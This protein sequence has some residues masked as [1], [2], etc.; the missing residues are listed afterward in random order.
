MSTAAEPVVGGEV[1]G[2][3]R[4]RRS[5]GNKL[6]RRRGPRAN[7]ESKPEG[8]T[9]VRAERPESIPVPA[10]M[11]GQRKIGIVSVVVRRGKMKFGFI[12]IGDD[13]KDEDKNPRI[14]F[15]F[16]NLANAGD[17][18]RRSYIVEFMISKDDKDRAYASDI[19]LTEEGKAIAV[20]REKV[21]AQK[22]AE[23]AEDEARNGPRKE[24]APRERKPREE[25]LVTLTVSCEGMSEEKSLEFNVAQSVGRLK[26]I[27]TTAFDAPVHYN[28]FHV[29]AENPEGL[30]L[31][32]AIM[33]ALNPGDKIHLRAPK[34]EA[35]VA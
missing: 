10:E 5:P 17:I 27:A 15:S 34:E 2:R 22:N 33:A 31:T 7:G 16:E 6:R 29:S 20:E 35:A 28:V 9:R 25:K 26:N 3:S 19:S 13:L 12:S 30:F 14:Y 32:K 8:S 4:R 21:I 24:R 1:D 11:I 18:L 23:R